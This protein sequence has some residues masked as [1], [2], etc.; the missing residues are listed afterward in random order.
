MRLNGSRTPLYELDGCRV[1]GSHLVLG[2]A[3]WHPVSEDAR[4]SGPFAPAET[5]LYCLNTAGHII[6][7]IGT[8]NRTLLF[9]DWEEIAAADVSGQCGWTE[10]VLSMLNGKAAA[11]QPEAEMPLMPCDT[12]L[13]TRMGI[14]QAGDIKIGDLIG[15]VGADGEIHYTEVIGVVKGAAAV[16]QQIVNKD[17]TW[18]RIEGPACADGRAFFTESGTHLVFGSDGRTYHIRDFSEVGSENIHLT[19]P[20]VASRLLVTQSPSAQQAQPSSG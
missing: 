3:G 1:S 8:A 16:T 19:Y 10:L 4:A 5:E 2:L 13:P 12:L 17:G 14:A 15:D 6:P 18:I 11:S 7:V 9:R 20:Y